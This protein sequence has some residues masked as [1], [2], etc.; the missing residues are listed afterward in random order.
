MVTKN[1]FKVYKL[2]LLILLPL[3]LL[4]PLISAVSTLSM[5]QKGNAFSNNVYGAYL[6]SNHCSPNTCGWVSGDEIILGIDPSG[7][8]HDD[9]A[10]WY[11]NMSIPLDQIRSAQLII[12]WPNFYGKGLHSPSPYSH[13]TISWNS[14]FSQFIGDTPMNQAISCGNTDYYAFPCTQYSANYTIPIS[15]LN[16]TNMLR[17]YSS[18]G[19]IWDIGTVELRITYGPEATNGVRVVNGKVKI[20]GNDFMIKGIDYAPWLTGQGPDAT[21]WQ[22][23]YPNANDDVTSLVTLNGFKS[24]K[25]YNGDGKIQAWEVIKYDVETMRKTGANTI[26][27]YAT[28]SWHDKNLN[29]AVDYSSNIN[30]NEVVQ[31]D[32]PDWIIDELLKDAQ[33]NNMKVIIGYWVQEENFKESPLVCNWDDLIVAKQSLGRIIQKYKSNPAVLGWGIG[34]EVNGNWNQGWFSWGVPVNDYLNSLFDYAKGLDDTHPTI[35]AKYLGENTNFNN[36]HADIIAINA[37]MSSASSLLSGG[38]FS[39]V[40]PQGRAYML[41]EFGHVLDQAADQWTLAQ[42]Y[43]GGAFLEYNNVWWKG[44]GQNLMGIV[45]AFRNK[46]DS[47]YSVVNNIY[48]GLPVCSS[49][50]ECGTNGYLGSLTCSSNNILQTYRTY[51]CNNPNTRNAS[52]SSTDSIKIKQ[53][54]SDICTGSG[55]CSTQM[56]LVRAAADIN[57]DGI[58]ELILQDTT[59][60]NLIKYLNSSANVKNASFIGSSA[61]WQIKA[62]GDLNKDGIADLIFQEPTGKAAVWFMNSSNLAKSTAVIASGLGSWQLRASGDL[63]KDGVS[64]YVFETSNGDLAIWFVKTDGTIRTAKS[65]GNIGN[66]QV[67]AMADVDKDGIADL[68][69]QEPSG[70]AAIWYMKMDGTAKSTAV[71]ASGLG[72]WQIKATADVDKDG[73]SDLIFQE[74]GGKIAIW[75]M[76]ANGSMRSSAIIN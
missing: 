28:G 55:V 5:V 7:T 63:D 48:G 32:L 1:H 70:K 58:I 57:K 25:D 51:T 69:F 29:G 36:L 44:D 52:C 31:G 8:I 2:F 15:Q 13:G 19:S 76:N 18:G 39:L 21:Q 16:S 33:A 9:Y 66:W 12:T 40:A 65:L 27:T 37:Y 75:F 22:K 60:N 64:D 6:A 71:I 46:V 24:V 53:T 41:G 26:R 61:G 35:Y 34:N 68:I 47:R 38:E 56:F 67:R 11:F 62:A 42:N 4:S 43:A 23:P 49:N 45:D 14:E 74:P 54:C 10:Y 59:G 17:I 50:S 72:A 20:D 3:L 73:I 30:K